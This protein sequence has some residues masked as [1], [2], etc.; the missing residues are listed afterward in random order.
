MLSFLSKVLVRSPLGQK[1]AQVFSTRGPSIPYG[2]ETRTII[3]RGQPSLQRGKVQ[4]LAL[5][6]QGA[7][8]D[9]CCPSLRDLSPLHL[10]LE[11][12]PEI[13]CQPLNLADMEAW[14]PGLARSKQRKQPVQIYTTIN[15]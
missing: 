10:F 1:F 14:M 12:F 2:K 13:F 3:L 15:G 4:G 5:G 8:T 9:L 11:E 7:H 6:M